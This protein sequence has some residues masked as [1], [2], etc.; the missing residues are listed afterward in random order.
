MG[1]SWGGGGK[2]SPGIWVATQKETV[3][4][5]MELYDRSH[6]SELSILIPD[7][8]SKCLKL[9]AQMSSSFGHH[10]DAV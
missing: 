3:L 8:R 7:C 1:L 4:S 5:P 6:D 2:A 10:A 9:A